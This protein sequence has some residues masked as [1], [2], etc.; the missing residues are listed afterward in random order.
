[1]NRYTSW[2]CLVAVMGFALLGTVVGST[3]HD[4]LAHSEGFVFTPLV[5][6]GTPAPQEGDTFLDV[7]ESNRINNRGD[8]LFTSLVITGELPEDGLFLL[9]KGEVAQIARAGED[10][11]GGGVFGPGSL[12]PTTLND[13]GDVGFVYLLEPFSFPDPIE[14]PPFG[15]NAG[16]YRFSQSTHMVTAAMRPGVTLAPGGE[17]FA[18]AHFGAS[19]NNWGDLVFAG[20]VPTDQ[21]IHL[22]DE[23]YSGLGVGI[24]KADKKGHIVS[25]V[26][27]GDPAP[28][29]GVFDTAAAPW[30]NDRGDVAFMGHITGEECRAQGFPPQTIVIGCLGS[31]YVREASTGDIRSIAHAGDSA[32]GGGVYRQAIGPVINNRG[33]IAFLGDL[34]SAPAARMVTGVYLHSGGETIPV[35]RP[36]NPMPGGGSFVTASNIVGWQLHLNNA[37]EV[38]FNATL[39]TDDNA[40]GIPDTGLYVWSHGSLRLVARTGTVIPGVGTTA[41]LVMNVLVALESPVFVPNSGAHN[42]D[43]GQVVFGAMLCDAGATP[44]ATSDSRG[45]LLVATPK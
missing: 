39:D 27:P 41:H 34:T 36:G 9:R 35:A 37:G 26:S 43:R 18:G 1:M 13:K 21:G 11:P 3:S 25:V 28:G 10:A 7:F 38:V 32:P 23:A 42:N 33:D 22:D 4:V 17:L 5:F 30:M 2:Q 29:G 6:L 24:F 40:D 12:S 19:L 15:V 44:C 20:M 14:G 31:V 45:V 16:V 8:V